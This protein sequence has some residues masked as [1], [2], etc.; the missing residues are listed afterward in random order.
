M[1]KVIIAGGRDFYNSQRV[2]NVMTLLLKNH[3]YSQVE[4]VC[5]GARGAD[6]LGEKWALAEGVGLSYFYPDWDNNGKAAG[7]IR[8]RQMGDYAD[9]LVAFWDGTSKGTKSMIDYMNKLKKPTRVI[10]Y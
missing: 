3:D 4:V 2:M 1:L 7:H 10:R 5:G 9:C 8:N 6:S